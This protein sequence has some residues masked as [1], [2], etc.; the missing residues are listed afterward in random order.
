MTYLTDCPTCDLTFEATDD[1]YGPQTYCD[2]C[3]DPGEGYEV[4]PGTN[5]PGPD[6]SFYDGGRLVKG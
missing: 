6:L 3:G 1:C 2:D 5:G 4:D